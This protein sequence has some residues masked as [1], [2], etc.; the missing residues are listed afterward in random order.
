MTPEERLVRLEERQAHNDRQLE[1]MDRKLDQL[2][3]A[4]AMGRGA[5]WAMLKLGGALVMLGSVVAW[6][7]DRLHFFNWNHL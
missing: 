5:W 3:E 2:L 7:G 1:E 6:V 4:A